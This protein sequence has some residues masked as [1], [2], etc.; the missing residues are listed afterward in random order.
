MGRGN[1]AT[2]G[3][4]EEPRKS[5][6]GIQGP[7]KVELDAET[8]RMLESRARDAEA[9]HLGD[10]HVKRTAQAEADI[11]RIDGLVGANAP[12][13]GNMGRSGRSQFKYPT[14]K[15]H[16]MFPLGKICFAGRSG[17]V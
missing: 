16:R 9:E 13:S 17:R 4:T 14:Q 5:E 6:V 10:R 2:P 12:S 3:E 8:G 7:R 11:H 1:K 15:T